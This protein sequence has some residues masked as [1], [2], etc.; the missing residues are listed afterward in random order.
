[1]GA[2]S[3]CSFDARHVFEVAAAVM[4]MHM[5]WA[6][7]ASGMC[8]V[9]ACVQHLQRKSNRYTWFHINMCHWKII[10]FP[11]DMLTA[12]TLVCQRLRSATWAPLLEIS[13]GCP[14]DAAQGDIKYLFELGSLLCCKSLFQH[15]LEMLG[16]WQQAGQR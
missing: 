13:L 4:T 5:L 2:Y 8:I 16:T 3:L 11:C 15:R 1:M 7:P 9:V 10:A 12:E 14:A 6:R